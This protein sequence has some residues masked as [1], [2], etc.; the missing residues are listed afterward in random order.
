MRKFYLL[1]LLSLGLFFSSCKKDD[2][3]TTSVDQIE[4]ISHLPLSTMSYLNGNYKD[5][6]AK[7]T[8]LEEYLLKSKN[9]N[10]VGTSDLR[11][12]IE[13][14]SQ[15]RYHLGLIS[16]KFD[17]WTY[18]DKGEID[19]RIKYDNVSDPR[20][21]DLLDDMGWHEGT[22][23]YTISY[24]GLLLIPALYIQTDPTTQDFGFT[25]KF[26]Y[27]RDGKPIAKYEKTWTNLGGITLTEQNIKVIDL[28]HFPFLWGLR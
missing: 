21:S 2:P 24:R 16:Q 15:D 25:L 11:V 13:F 8:I 22:W 18:N 26:K 5:H 12:D 20:D 27:Y 19:L 23:S 14:Y 6:D 9:I 3:S 28:L 7:T 1:S 10:D 17:T 4:D